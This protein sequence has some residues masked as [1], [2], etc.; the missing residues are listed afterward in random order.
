M[1]FENWES[2]SQLQTMTNKS[3]D[4]ETDKQCSELIEQNILEQ[5]LFWKLS[6]VN[7]QD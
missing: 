5:I 7:V 3:E 1:R 4:N 6:V 2:E